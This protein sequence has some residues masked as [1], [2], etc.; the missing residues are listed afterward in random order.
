MSHLGAPN[1]QTITT[2]LKRDINFTGSNFKYSY[3]E[4]LFQCINWCLQF[5]IC[6]S[7]T[8][9]RKIGL[10]YLKTKDTGDK[11]I[12]DDFTKRYD[13]LT[14]SC[15]R[16]YIQSCAISIRQSRILFFFPIENFKASVQF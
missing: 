5:D 9:D 4:D 7:I 16:K 12:M 3:I 15:L 11:I 14:I 2:C 10:C 1:Q 13:S 6:K 8:W